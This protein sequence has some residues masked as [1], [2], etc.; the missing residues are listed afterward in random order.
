LKKNPLTWNNAMTEVVRRIK[1]KVQI[2]PP[3]S[4]PTREGNYIIEIDASN[5][6]WTSV[7]IEEINGVETVCSYAS[8]SFRGEEI[9]YPSIHKEILVVKK[10]VLHFRLYL[11]PV[12]FLI[13]SDLKILPGMLKSEN[14]LTKSHSRIK[15]WILWLDNFDFTV[16]HKP[17]HLNCLVDMLTREAKTADLAMFSAE[18]SNK[19]KQ[20]MTQEEED[21]AQATRRKEV[22]T[23]VSQEFIEM[24]IRERE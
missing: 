12:K 5:S 3:L 2:L 10:T 14:L 7:L 6:T 16:Q 17:G 24:M 15:K 1:D 8:G 4:L 23:I 21:R 19:G 13:R 11:K 22:L 20:P 9:N 18:P